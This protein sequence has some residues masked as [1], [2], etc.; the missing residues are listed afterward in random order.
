MVDGDPNRAPERVRLDGVPETMLWTLHNRAS[1][2]RRTDTPLHDPDAVRI[3]DA[4]DYPFAETFGKPDSSHAYRALVFDREVAAHLAAHPGCTVVEL[5]AGLETQARRL[6]DGIVRW[7]AVDLPESVAV[8]ERFL[9]TTARHRNLAL[10]ATDLRWVDEVD[11]STG[12]PIVTAGGLLMYLPEEQVRDLLVGI[13]ERL[14][15]ATVVFDVIPRWLSRWT[16]RGY[17]KT[18]R[19][20]T[21]PM[22]WGLDVREAPALL[23]WSSRFTALTELHPEPF[24]RLGRA[25]SLASRLPVVG[26]RRPS[27]W[28][29]DTAS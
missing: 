1:I 21:P 19:Y 29:L 5:A 14:P 22:P 28:R 9:P 23:D 17:R 2:A 11:V 27:M 20:T 13:A 8:R 4:I 16:L 10:S 6:D 3:I 26:R 7:L 24:D 18:K 25:I 12:P 15:G